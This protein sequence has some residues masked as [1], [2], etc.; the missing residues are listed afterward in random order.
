MIRI[1]LPPLRDRP[2]DIPRFVTH[3]LAQQ[4]RRGL[5]EKTVTPQA[6][7]VLQSYRWPGNVRE[8]ANTVERLMIPTSGPTIDVGDLP[9]TLRADPG[10]LPADDGALTLAYPDLGRA[11]RLDPR[12]PGLARRDA[13]A[14]HSGSVKEASPSAALRSGLP[15]VGGTLAV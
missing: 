4:R 9:D 8:L 3:F 12:A 7:R 10:A 13:V 11:P 6:L 15:T 2:G 5:G 1:T 14:A